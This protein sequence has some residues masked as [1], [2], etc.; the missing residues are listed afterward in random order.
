MYLGKPPPIRLLGLNRL[1]IRL[2]GLAFVLGE[3]A[4][5]AVDIL[6]R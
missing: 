6:V 2:G 1:T 4:R 3:Q 5:G